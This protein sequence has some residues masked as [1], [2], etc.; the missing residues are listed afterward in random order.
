MDVETFARDGPAPTILYAALGGSSSVK[1]GSFD[2]ND[3][4]LRNLFARESRLV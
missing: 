4:Q 2:M 1:R 3:Y